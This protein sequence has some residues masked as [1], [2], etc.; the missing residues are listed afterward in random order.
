MKRA[1]M[2]HK[3]LSYNGDSYQYHRSGKYFKVNVFVEELA[4]QT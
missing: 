3:P 4:K 1:R 2:K